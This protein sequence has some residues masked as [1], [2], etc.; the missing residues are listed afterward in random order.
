MRVLIFIVL[1][2][3]VACTSKDSRDRKGSSV[4]ADRVFWG[5]DIITMEGDV[6]HYVEA[7]AVK[8][9]KII[10]LGSKS[11][12]D[13][14]IGSETQLTNLNGK[15]LLP[16]FIDGHSH[17]TKYADGLMQADLNAPPVG[18]VESIQD[19]ISALK[20]LKKD[21]QLSDTSWIIGA[22]Y[23]HEMLEEKR[24]PTAA[25]LD[26]E[27]PNN[28]VLLIHASNHMLVANSAAFRIAGVT[29]E[30]KDPDGGTFIR[31]KG[32]REPEGLVQEM[33]QYA[34][35][36]FLVGDF[37]D[38]EEFDKLKRAQEYYASQGLT[39]VSEH[40]A[41]PEKQ[42]ML[43]KAA[44]QQVLYLDVE[45]LP[46]HTYAA[47]LIDSGK[48]K[49][50]VFNN[51]LKFAGVKMVTDGSPQ[52]KTAFLSSP[53]LT[54]VPGCSHDCRGFSNMSQEQI[55]AL[56]VLCYTNNVQ[57][58][59]HCNGD[60]AIDM[61]IEGHRFAN[62][63]L[64]D[65]ITDRRTVV[66]HSQVVRAD[67]LDAYK[68]YQMIPSFF[69]NHCFYWGDAH[70]ANLG[71]ERAGFI[72]PLNTAMKKGIVC[73]NHTDCPVTPMDQMFL[74]WTSVARQT[75]SGKS[76]GKA[77]ALTPYQG[78][79][80]LTINVAYQFFEEELKG[81]LSAGKMADLVILDRNPL[82]VKTDEIPEIKV[83]ETIKEGKTVFLKK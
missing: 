26:K 72:S 83:Q 14:L 54:A 71:E 55:N 52:G 73:T 24:H 20:D 21:R 62:A 75:R 34:F 77:E 67:Q 56:M 30:T 80:V 27:F 43:E 16:G 7:L 46:S 79:K 38:E 31:K 36:D 15:T 65:S 12:I 23:D 81:T 57:V 37:S 19:I 22:G 13:T 35:Y 47:A 39:T 3:F 42:V 25:D 40:M 28:P 9:G 63:Q 1:L 53:Y 50:G 5:G 48:V 76:I 32:S 18:K 69:S 61:M 4:V 6:P 10:A 33:A 70:I 11:H 59:S 29:A 78:L 68:Q 66:I 45:M 2:F 49:W 82:K 8:N 64:N 58:Y 44:S 51:H 41:V 17:L 60:A 74:L